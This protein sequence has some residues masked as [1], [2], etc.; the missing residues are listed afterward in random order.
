MIR[1]ALT[2]TRGRMGQLIAKAVVAD[3][4]VALV[5]NEKEATRCDVFIDFTA[6][7]ATLE[8]LKIASALKV[9]LV[10]GTTGFTQTE[11]DLITEASTLIPIVYSPNMSIG[12]NLVYQL[13]SVATDILKERAEVGIIDI[14]HR[15]KKDAPS[16][17]ALRM[18][19]VIEEAGIKPQQIQISSLRLGEAIGMHQALFSWGVEEID[20]THRATNRDCFAAGALL[21]AKWI[22]GKSPGLYSMQ[23][24]LKV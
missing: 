9:P 14:H 21:A 16:G 18:A 10:I 24:V 2:G 23:D 22:T 19:E 20:I 12:I 17:T 4:T 3:E 11:K 6:P 13:L 7:V 15:H 8:Y 5:S 1:I